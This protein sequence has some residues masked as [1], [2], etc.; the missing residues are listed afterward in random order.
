[1][2]EALS[3]VIQVL[4]T[5]EIRR[6]VAEAIETGS[7]I[8]CSAIAAQVSRTYPNNGMTEPQVADEVMIAA[9]KAGVAVEFGQLASMR[10]PSH[11]AE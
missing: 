11:A 7:T 10:K 3:S 8:S 5:E 1:M 9:S 4:V 2:G 6:T